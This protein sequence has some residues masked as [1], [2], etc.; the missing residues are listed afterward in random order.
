[1]RL[2]AARKEDSSQEGAD[3]GEQDID[4][5]QSERLCQEPDQGG[6]GDA[7]R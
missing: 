7:K 5:R 6:E 2:G 3:D 1:M 4:A